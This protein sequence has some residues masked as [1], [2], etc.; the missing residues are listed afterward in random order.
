ML[1]RRAVG[2]GEAGDLLP[3]RQHN[4]TR[5]AGILA[6]EHPRSN[7]ATGLRR[8]IDPKSAYELRKSGWR[9]WRIVYALTV[10]IL[11]GHGPFQSSDAVRWG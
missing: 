9:S 5:T 3:I 11:D 4:I 7:A 2:L 1:F 10:A 6:S 8:P